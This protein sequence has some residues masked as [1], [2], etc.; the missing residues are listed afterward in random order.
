MKNPMS[1]SLWIAPTFE[2]TLGMKLK[3]NFTE[4]GR[5]H[6]EYLDGE[7]RK[8]SVSPE[9]TRRLGIDAI[10]ACFY[11]LENILLG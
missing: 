8:H 2:L 3:A 5:I 11:L 4:Y 10:G 6:L 7:G 1:F 9:P